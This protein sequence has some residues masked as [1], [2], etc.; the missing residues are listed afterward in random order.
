MRDNGFKMV[1]V[2]TVIGVI[3]ATALA[4][5]NSMTKEKI[6]YQY[7]LELLK[8]LKVVLPEYDNSPDKDLKV[9][10]GKTVYVAKKGGKIVGYAVKSISEKGY[11][12]SI[13]VLIGVDINGKIS[14]IEILKHAETPGLGSKIEEKW[15]KDEFKGL[16]LKDNIAVKKDG[17]I[18]D[19]FSGATISPRAVSEAV[20]NGLKFIVKDV[21]EGSK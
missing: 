11:G 15:F 2:L 6:E 12:G 19:Q 5:V 4:I 20:K 8:A 10:G 18:I 14:G 9:I 16:T 17:G 21:L 7:R 13:V 1:F 3:A